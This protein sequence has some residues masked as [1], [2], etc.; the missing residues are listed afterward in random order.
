M[1]DAVDYLRTLARAKSCT[2][3]AAWAEAAALWERV[4]EANPVNGNHWDRLAEARLELGEYATALTAYEKVAELGVWEWRESIFPG[5]PQARIACCHA[6]LGD[7]EAAFA[8]LRLALE[9]RF[10]D[11]DMLRTSEHLAKLRDDPRFA[12]LLGLEDVEGLGRDEGWRADLRLLAREVD[13]RPPLAL[14]EE[15]SRRFHAELE[16]LREAIPELTD[17]RIAVELW[18]LLRLLGDGHAS[19]EAPPDNEELNLLLPLQFYLF[20]EGVFVTA[21]DPAYEEL[22]G[23][24]VVM[25]DGRLIDQVLQAIDPLIC[26]D[27]EQR[28]KELSPAWLRRTPFLHALGVVEAS[29]KV[30]L[31][32]R[33][34]PQAT[35]T[36]Q[37]EATRDVASRHSS[38]PAPAGWSFFPERLDSS[39]PLYLRNCAAS[40]WFEHLPEH[41]LV[42]FQF[43]RVGDDSDESLDAFSRRMF[44]FIE[45]SDVDKLVVDLRWNGGGNLFLSHPLLY[46]MMSCSK[47]NRKGGLFAIVGRRTFSAAGYTATW[48]DSHTEA[49][50]V[51]EPVGTSPNCVGETVPFVLPYSRFRVNVSDLYWQNSSPMDRRPWIAPELY[52]PPTFE[53]YRENRDPAMEAILAIASS[54][55]H[56]PG[57]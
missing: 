45:H 37:V 33:N 13:R 52:A 4:V 38:L 30:T 25:I 34:D 21:T 26:R 20:E 43:N 46:G 24:E 54:K 8:A 44:D 27:N 23:T 15:T 29:D 47:V 56:L 5:V 1:G 2:D 17:A 42:Y 7:V 51:G 32:V 10:R 40:Y 12:E 22:L 48:I 55:E 6:E 9:N 31:T 49:I 28:S 36:V 41:R 18:K 11:L 50:V 39:L 3:R 19:L 16:R 14:P 53:A 35:R 57:W